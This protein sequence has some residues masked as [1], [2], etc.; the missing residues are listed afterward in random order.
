[1]VFAAKFAGIAHIRSVPAELA[2]LRQSSERIMVDTCSLSAPT[3][4]KKQILKLC[5]LVKISK[6]T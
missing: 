3:N 5:T 4:R 1:M 2:S 6:R